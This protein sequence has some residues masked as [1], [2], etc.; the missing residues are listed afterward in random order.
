MFL[1]IERNDIATVSPVSNH[2]NNVPSGAE[3]A[4]TST[5]SAR[6]AEK[7]RRDSLLV[8]TSLTR[9]TAEYGPIECD[10]V[11]YFSIESYSPGCPARIYGDPDDC[12]PAEA[13]EYDFAIDLIEFDGGEVDDAPGPLTPAEIETLTAWFKGDGNEAACEKADGR[14]EAWE[15]R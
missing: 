6:K 13:A 9:D 12:Y 5:V 3:C 11:I 2:I 7:I 8:C 1:T 10:I 14:I 15:F 4:I